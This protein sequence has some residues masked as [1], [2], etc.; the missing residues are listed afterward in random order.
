MIVPAWLD[1]VTTLGVT[2]GAST[3]ETLVADV[4]ERVRQLDPGFITVEPVGTGEP[5]MTFRPPRELAELLP[6][7]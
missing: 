1:G 6:P 3:P 4:I 2:A 5:A 7:A